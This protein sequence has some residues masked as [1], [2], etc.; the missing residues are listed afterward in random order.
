[1]AA[2]IP[3]GALSNFSN[4]II[5]NFGYTSKQTLILSTPGGAVAALMTLF[6]GWYA[7]KKKERMIPIIFALVPTIVGS[8]ILIGLN[9]HNDK[10]G[11]LLFGAYLTFSHGSSLSIIYAYNA[12]NTSGH[13]KKSTVNAITLAAF[14]LGNIIGSEIFLPKDAPA[15]IPGKVA[16]MILLTA[17]L[18][19][20][21]LLRWINVR[22][23]AKRKARIEEEKRQR[24]WTDADVQRE[25]ERH[26]F[27]DMTDK[28]NIYFEYM[29]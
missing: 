23:N 16:I 9:G 22:L 15:Y 25:R 21:F 5:R 8:A 4:I 29:A 2:S 7:D 17:M 10:K 13:T 18:F 27:A 12:S 11:V 3:N 19:V 1:M 20:C 14:S 24:G 28:E 26:A 6:I